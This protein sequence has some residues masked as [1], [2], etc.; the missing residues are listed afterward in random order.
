MKKRKRKK[1][2]ASNQKPKRKKP[3][4]TSEIIGI[5][6]SFL[7]IF[8]FVSLIS[9]DSK[10]P[11]WASAAP[12]D[13]KI[14]NYAGKAGASLAEALLQLLGF[15]S[16]LLPF[17]FVYLGYQTFLRKENKRLFL[18]TGGV[19]LLV[20]IISA[21]LYMIFQNP[22]WR[23]TKILAGGMIGELFSSFLIRYFNRLG[24]LLILISFLILFFI[25][26]TKFSI[27]KA[28]HFFSKIFSFTF[29]EVRIRITHYQKSKRRE[30]M[31]KKITEKYSS[32]ARKTKPEK[33]AEK[34]A[35]KKEIKKEPKQE[36]PL[37]KPAPPM[38]EKLLFPEME[39]R[40][41]Y[42]F[43]PFNL[44]DPGK[45]YEK[46]DKNELYEKKQKIEEKLR[47]P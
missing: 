24:T 19:F 43:P 14:S 46:I 15:A 47:E 44:L 16:F 28:F 5:S 21:L 11:S 23:G 36:I 6:L 10:D 29:K 18:K 30:K 40:G 4:R 8:L 7:A 45:V 39:K 3:L 25:F 20:F 12:S 9:Y 31:R 38:P 2:A 33:T 41:G 42:Q 32:L 37:T 34:K 22:S 27:E 26:S 13:Q 35:K 17:A 1:Q